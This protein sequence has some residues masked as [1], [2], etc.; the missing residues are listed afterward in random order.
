MRLSDSLYYHE[1]GKKHSHKARN[2]AIAGAG[3]AATALLPAAKVAK[4]AKGLGRIGRRTGTGVGRA[5][6]AG[7]GVRSVTAAGRSVSSRA[8]RKIGGIRSS[9]RARQAGIATKR[10]DR[11]LR[12]SLAAKLTPERSARIA[13]RRAQSGAGTA[14]GA[15]PTAASRAKVGSGLRQKQAVQS[16]RQAKIA[17]LRQRQIGAQQDLD[18]I[19]RRIKRKTSF[20]DQIYKYHKETLNAA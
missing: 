5:S 3:L 13:R 20:S 16:Q 12:Q 7:A 4:V 6:V 14:A 1:T 8:S 19:R 15:G 10:R 17:A 18:K 11:R 9:I 2:I